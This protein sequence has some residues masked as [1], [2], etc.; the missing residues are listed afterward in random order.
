M[1]SA[2]YLQVKGRTKGL[3]SGSGGLYEREVIGVIQ[4]FFSDIKH[5]IANLFFNSASEYYGAYLQNFLS[6]KV[7]DSQICH[8]FNK[9]TSINGLIS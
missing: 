9:A 1:E 6:K 3:I 7:L 2:F 5:S 4:S 8:I